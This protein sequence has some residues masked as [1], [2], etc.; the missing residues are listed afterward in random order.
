MKARNY[1]EVFHN[2]VMGKLQRSMNYWQVGRNLRWERGWNNWIREEWEYGFIQY[3][4]I[5]QI[6]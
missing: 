2:K 4:F 3:K 1:C 6:L 5:A